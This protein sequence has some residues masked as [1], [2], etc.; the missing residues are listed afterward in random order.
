MSWAGAGVATVG[1][2]L[3]L[4]ASVGLVRLHDPISR[5]QVVSKASTLG[6]ALCMAGTVLMVPALAVAV[7]AALATL[8]LIIVTPV[9]GHLVGRAA[10]RSGLTG[11]LAVDELADDALS[12][13]GEADVE[14]TDDIEPT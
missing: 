9:T 1:A 6:V 11:H 12:T 5:L 13:R 10:Y 2:M 4:L 14:G 7:K 8:L 3:C